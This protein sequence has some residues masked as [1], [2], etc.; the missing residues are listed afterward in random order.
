[1]SA[2]AIYPLAGPP[3]QLDRRFLEEIQRIGI[4]P[5][6]L[7]GDGEGSES[8]RFVS[9]RTQNEAAGFVAELAA[10]PRFAESMLVRGIERAL[11]QEIYESGDLL[12]RWTRLEGAV[13][14][15][16]HICRPDGKLV[17]PMYNYPVFV[18][19][20]ATAPAGREGRTQTLL[21]VLDGY[22]GSE[23]KRSI[24]RHC[25]PSARACRSIP[26]QFI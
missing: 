20:G 19:G 15:T 2:R 22:A 12:Y 3:S 1:M 13:G 16:A 17:H 14:E 25:L 9:C 10:L 7:V 21:G 23:G 6:I 4:H 18:F 11:Q 24:T 26:I 8:G 5:F